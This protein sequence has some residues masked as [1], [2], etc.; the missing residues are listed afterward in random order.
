MKDLCLKLL[1]A[2]TE[3]E[4]I[5][6]VKKYGYW[7]D[8]SL[9]KPY[10][11]IPNNRSIVGNQQSFSVAALV[12]K[13]VNSIDAILMSECYQKGVDPKSLEAPKSMREAAELFFGI[14]DGRI[15][16]L[17][18]SERRMLLGIIS[19]DNT[20]TVKQINT[21]FPVPGK[22]ICNDLLRTHRTQ[23][24]LNMLISP[25]PAI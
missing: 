11:D 9:W 12:E 21:L 19:T 2:E 13:L 17:D 24:F 18:Q 20:H 15:Q 8:R 10:G 23:G 4:V 14:K 7:D 25:S 1:R 3:E 6:I 5:E 22:L 16:N